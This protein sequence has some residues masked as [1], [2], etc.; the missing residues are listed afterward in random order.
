MITDAKI[1]VVYSDFWMNVT[2]YRFGDNVQDVRV[3]VNYHNTTDP[4]PAIWER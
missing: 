4:T 1:R 2:Y 3:N